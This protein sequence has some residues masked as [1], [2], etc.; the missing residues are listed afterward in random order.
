MLIV[1]QALCILSMCSG[2]DQWWSGTNP[3]SLWNPVF[4]VFFDIQAAA[5]VGSIEGM[6]RRAAI[7]LSRVYSAGL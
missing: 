1:K 6:R 5:S 2:T 4:S 3:L 7:W